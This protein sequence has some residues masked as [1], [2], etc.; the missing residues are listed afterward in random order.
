MPTPEKMT[1]EDVNERG[2]VVPPLSSDEI[3]YLIDRQVNPDSDVQYK[4]YS[5]TALDALVKSGSHFRVARAPQA[6]AD[7]LKAY[8]TD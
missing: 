1:W 2:L 8:M 7:A 3:R 4:S 6:T 5:G